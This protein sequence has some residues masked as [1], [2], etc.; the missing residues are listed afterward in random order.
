MKY[1]TRIYYTEKDKALTC[2]QLAPPT[3]KTVGT[4]T[5]CAMC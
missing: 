1:P 5:I 3:R 4:V 2:A